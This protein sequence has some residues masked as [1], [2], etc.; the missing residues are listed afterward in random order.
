MEGG[1][2]LENPLGRG[3]DT[4]MG[5]VEQSPSSPGKLVPPLFNGTPPYVESQSD[6]QMRGVRRCERDSLMYHGRGIHQGQGSRQEHDAQRL[7]QVCSGGR[8]GP[9][10]TLKKACECGSGTVDI[11]MGAYP[12]QDTATSPGVGGRTLPRWGTP[13]SSKNLIFFNCTRDLW[14]SRGGCRRTRRTR[15][16]CST[17]Q[18]HEGLD[19]QAVE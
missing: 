13:C 10:S 12:P 6:T 14:C 19:D 3:G 9:N 1:G 15:R 5:G 2:P 16:R 11:D 8:A 18:G 7:G 4:P 17:K